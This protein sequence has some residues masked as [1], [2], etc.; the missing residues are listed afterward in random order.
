MENP[1]FTR[2]NYL[3]LAKMAQ[4]TERYFEMIEYI[5][6][7]IPSKTDLSSEERSIVSAAYK[8][9]VGNK[10]AE[11]RV[12]CAIEQKEQRKGND[13]HTSYIKNYKATIES[14][15][16]TFCN[17]ILG[18][19]ENQLI[20]NSKPD[21]KIFYL[22]MKGD[23]NRYLSEFLID[24]EYNEVVEHGKQSY[25]EAEK[26]A[27]DYL[28]PTDPVRLGLYLNM[29]VFYYEILQQPDEAIRMANQ[30]FD[31]AISSI[32]NVNEENYKDCTLIMQL[33]RDNLTLWSSDMAVEEGNNEDM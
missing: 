17:E 33:L 24:Q 32:D 1:N 12:L 14:E 10:R 6:K 5:Q 29:S 27:L 19:L 20:P 2:E 31:E 15:L 28:P 7:L 9:V 11:L 23:Y 13:Q 18:I 25:L 21:S 16:R 4:Q 30:A 22:K 26:L 3:L 8:S